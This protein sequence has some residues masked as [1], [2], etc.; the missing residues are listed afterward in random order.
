MLPLSTFPDPAAV[1]DALSLTRGAKVRHGIDVLD[2]NDRP[3]MQN[4][5]PQTLRFDPKGSAVSWDYRAADL[6]AGQSDEIAETRRTATL[7]LAGDIGVNLNAVRL[8]V[9]TE[10]RLLDGSWARF[11]MGVFEVVNPGAVVDDGL[12]VRRTV[13]CVDKSYRWA[14]TCNTDIE[15]APEIADSQREQE[16]AERARAE[17]GD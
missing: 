3:V 11:P 6:L 12:V 13:T 10:W 8:R 16:E 1:E 15:F 17:G 4:G 14:M 5:K 2:L 9:W 7:S